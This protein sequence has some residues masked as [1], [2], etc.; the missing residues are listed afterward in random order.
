MK[1]YFVK[2]GK[3]Y[4]TDFELNEPKKGVRSIQ[5]PRY[6]ESEFVPVLSAEKREI[7]PITLKGFMSTLIEWS[8]W[9]KC[10]EK[11]VIEIEEA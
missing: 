2:V 8:K 10:P 11:V 5:S 3:K 1:R 4:L 9:N 6:S 7:D